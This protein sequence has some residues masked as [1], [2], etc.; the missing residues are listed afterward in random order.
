ML[1]D[2]GIAERKTAAVYLRECEHAG[3]LRGKKVGR[4][5]LYLNVSLYKLLSK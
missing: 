2:A 4:E 1:V 3:I 5:V